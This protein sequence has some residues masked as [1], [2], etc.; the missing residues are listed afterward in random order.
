LFS[1]LAEFARILAELFSEFAEIA[2][3]FPEK[4]SRL[5]TANAARLFVDQWTTSTPYPPNARLDS[6]ARCLRIR[7]RAVA[8]VAL[9]LASS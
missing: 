4:A 5:H 7:R 6:E 1:E 3:K 2:G 8:R 9:A